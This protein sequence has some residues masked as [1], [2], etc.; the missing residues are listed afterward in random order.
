MNVTT[1]NSINQ[2]YN[3]H[4]HTPEIVKGSDTQVLSKLF[5]EE[6]H[7][8]LS[9]QRQTLAEAAAEIQE[10]LKQLEETNP[11]A[12]EAQ[13]KAFVTA[14]IPPACRERFVGALQAGWKDA[15]TEFLDNA[16]L[17]VGIATL[18]GWKAAD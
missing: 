8:A 18:E 14:A 3:S 9:W 7:K 6:L 5:L 12:T 4:L 1:V 2:T 17:K 10:H 13:Q 11:T 15:I 16:Y